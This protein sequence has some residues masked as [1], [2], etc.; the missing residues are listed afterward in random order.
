MELNLYTNH[1]TTGVCSPPIANN[2]E[3]KINKK[4]NNQSHEAS[5][6]NLQNTVYI[7]YASHNSKCTT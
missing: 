7:N 6:A 3:N 4:Y 5:T 1:L 2:I